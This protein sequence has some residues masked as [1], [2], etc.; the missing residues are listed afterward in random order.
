MDSKLQRLVTTDGDLKI[1][2]IGLHDRYIVLGH[3]DGTVSSWYLK[4]GAKMMS[5]K[6]SEDKI[7]GVGC[8]FH[9]KDGV[10]MIFA[11]VSSGSIVTLS[12]RGNSF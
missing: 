5:V 3:E 10:V 7:V 4:N 2:C 9:A 12:Q 6:V 8:E 1:S 11:A